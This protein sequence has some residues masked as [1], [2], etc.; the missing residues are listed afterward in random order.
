ML[1]FDHKMLTIK[2]FRHLRKKLSF[3]K[4]HDQILIIHY[5]LKFHNYYCPTTLNVTL[6]LPYSTLL[7]RKFGINYLHKLINEK[8]IPSNLFFLIVTNQVNQ[9]LLVFINMHIYYLF[10]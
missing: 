2:L 3:L 10:F 4:I 9:L 6:G 5:F 7:S 1:V 8:I